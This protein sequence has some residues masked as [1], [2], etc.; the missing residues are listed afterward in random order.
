MKRIVCGLVIMV[1]FLAFAGLT[2]ADDNIKDKTALKTQSTEAAAFNKGSSGQ[3][4]F[5]PSK[6]GQKTNLLIPQRNQK[7]PNTRDANVNAAIPANRQTDDAKGNIK[8][9]FGSQAIKDTLAFHSAIITGF[10]VAPNALGDMNQDSLINI[11]DLL[12]TRNIWLGIGDSPSAY[13]L[14]EGDLDRNGVIDREDIDFFKDMLLQ[15]VGAPVLLDSAGGEV[16][17]AG[18]TFSFDSNAVESS[19]LLW[20]REVSKQEIFDSTGIDYSSFEQ[21]SVY[22]MKGFQLEGDTS[23]IL[24]PP[25]IQIELN[26]V[27]PCS[28]RGDNVLF[29][30]SVGPF[31]EPQLTYSGKLTVIDSGNGGSKAFPIVGYQPTNPHIEVVEGSEIPGAYYSFKCTGVSKYSSG[32]IFQYLLPNG[33]SIRVNP[34]QNDFEFGSD[35]IMIKTVAPYCSPG[36]ISLRYKLATKFSSWTD[37]GTLEVLPLPDFPP[38]LNPDSI[39][40]ATLSAADTYFV[41]LSNYVHANNLEFDSLVPGFFGYIDTLTQQM[42]YYFPQ[43]IDS[44]SSLESEQKAIIAQSFYSNNYY[45]II[46]EAIDSIRF[47][48]ND[49]SFILQNLDCYT[50]REKMILDLGTITLAMLDL[51]DIILWVGGPEIGLPGSLIIGSGGHLI[52]EE[53]SKINSACEDAQQ[54]PHQNGPKESGLPLIGGV[55]CNVWNHNTNC[56]FNLGYAAYC[57]CSDTYIK[58]N[59]NELN[60][61]RILTDNIHFVDLSIP[62]HWM[63]GSIITPDAASGFPPGVTGVVNDYGLAIIPGIRPGREVTFSLYNPTSGWYVPIVARTHSPNIPEQGVFFPLPVIFNVDT[64]AAIFPITIGNPVIDSATSTRHRFEYRF[65]VSSDIIDRQI[66]I[67]FHSDEGMTFWF[68]KPSGE[69]I[70]QDDS[71]TTSEFARRIVLDEVGIYKITTFYGAGGFGGPT[72]E[73]GI[74][75][76]PFYPIYT[77]C[78]TISGVLPLSFSPYTRILKVCISQADTLTAEAGVQVMISNLASISGHIHIPFMHILPSGVLTHLPGFIYGIDAIVDTLVIEPGGKLDVTGCG[79]RGTN[80]NGWGGP[81]SETYQGYL[82]S[83]HASGGSHGG[84]GGLGTYPNGV[85]PSDPGDVYDLV[86]DPFALGAGGSGAN[87]YVYNIGSMGGGLIRLNVGR[88]VLNGSIIADGANMANPAA[89]GGAGGT[90]N[91]RVGEIGGTGIIRADGGAG[92]PSYGG[93]GGGGRIAVRWQTGSISSLT[94][95][96][97]GGT[98]VNLGGA[99]TIYQLGPDDG[100]DGRLIV[101]NQ[102]RDGAITPLPNGRSQFKKVAILRAGKMEVGTYANAFSTSDSLLVRGT[103]S[104]L[105]LANNVTAGLI[106][107]KVDSSGTLINKTSLNFDN[108]LNLSLSNIGIIDNRNTGVFTISRFDSGNIA[109]GT[110]KNWGRLNILSDSIVVNTG[111]TLQEDGLLGASDSVSYMRVFGT[112]THGSR[113]NALLYDTNADTGAVFGVGELIIESGGKFDVSGCGYRGSQMYGWGQNRSESYP[114][115]LGSIQSTGGSHGGYGGLGTYPNG[116]PPDPGD[117]YDLVDDPFAMGAGSSG[118]NWYVYNIGSMGG[119]LIRLNVGRLV[120]NGSMVASGGNW[121]EINA[122]GGAGGTVNLRVGEIGGTGIIRADGGAG[123]PS[124]GGGGGGGRIAVRWQTGSISSLTISSQGGTGVNLG[125][126]G[127][128]YTNNG[129]KRSER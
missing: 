3:N 74:N 124:Y 105:T 49:I 102:G 125:G 26:S 32:N 103:S 106:G 18:V 1:M 41:E 115:Y 76:D 40:I 100:V 114:G 21:D 113:P 84:H 19:A 2:S 128:I 69:F 5:E 79:Y 46:K 12:R 48:R 94:I 93:G 9:L 87:Y 35:T 109:S 6:T 4:T 121:L 7:S 24:I 50:E 29:G 97:Q 23:A 38:N 53:L 126:A 70:I 34:I 127:T 129:S 72:F 65:A 62:K 82:G 92:N 99:G 36:V 73:L 90:V 17:G 22:F 59:N 55:C 78:D 11:W 10:H 101:D 75:F 120:L 71:S 117:V 107:V 85:G 54:D 95:S 108:A 118:G 15:K 63:T 123:N 16:S 45:Q 58:F 31:G 43:L 80:L 77:L 27:P 122:G 111:V 112:V 39:I 42:H 28:L 60:N 68:Q 30:A 14:I 64:T 37:V 66:T 110:F 91:L 51:L 56:E 33:D 86:D 8:E 89:G 25:S 47:D 52:F 44:I 104:Q 67:G 61:M 83:Y 81:R 57:D 119:G 96:S 98:G 20:V 13:E 88:L 116:G